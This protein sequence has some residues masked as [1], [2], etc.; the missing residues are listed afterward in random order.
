MTTFVERVVEPRETSIS[1]DFVSFTDLIA[2]HAAADPAG[3]AFT[4]GV[5]SLTWQDLAARVRQVACALAGSGIGAGDKVAIV[6]PIRA[7]PV[8]HHRRACLRGA[9]GDLGERRGA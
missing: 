7:M 1:A 3:I 9:A 6:P 5:D 8:R 2:A 4:D